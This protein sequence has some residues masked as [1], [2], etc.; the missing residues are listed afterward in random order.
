M[1]CSAGTTGEVLVV[2]EEGQQNFNPSSAP[3]A[4]LHLVPKHAHCTLHT[5]THQSRGVQNT[6]PA[7]QVARKE[8][9]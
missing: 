8:G 1:G 4:T 6:I 9:R 5:A 3:V 7:L 2:I